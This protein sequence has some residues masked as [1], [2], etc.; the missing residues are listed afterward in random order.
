MFYIL[1]FFYKKTSASFIPLGFLP[2][3]K[4]HTTYG[5]TTAEVGTVIS[6]GSV[7][8]KAGNDVNARQVSIYADEGPIAI[9]AGNN[10]TLEAGQT[11]FEG[12]GAFA[13]KAGKRKT[14]AVGEG[15]ATTDIGSTLSGQGVSIQA[16][17]AD[18]PAGQV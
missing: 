15:R 4:D 16:G 18:T 9:K 13:D 10:V 11:T 7:Y 12:S 17:N 8:M 3:I 5:N 2:F 14:S 6:S 1:A